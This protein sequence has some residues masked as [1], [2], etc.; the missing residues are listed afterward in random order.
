[1]SENETI[2]PEAA[3]KL[4]ERGLE[5]FYI[6]NTKAKVEGEFLEMLE[7]EG[8]LSSDTIQKIKDKATQDGSAFVVAVPDE[9]FRKTIHDVTV[10]CLIVNFVGGIMHIMRHL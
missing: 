7:R 2:S 3:A 8:H 4:L 1:M 10:A 9:A 6:L 5:N